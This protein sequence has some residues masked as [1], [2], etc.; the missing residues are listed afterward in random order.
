MGRASAQL[1]Q[2]LGRLEQTILAVWLRVMRKLLEMLRLHLPA[3][4]AGGG[5]P[6][7]NVKRRT[8]RS[9]R[10]AGVSPLALIRHRPA[11]VAGRIPSSI[12]AQQ[13]LECAGIQPPAYTLGP[14]HYGGDVLAIASLMLLESV[15]HWHWS[16]LRSRH[17]WPNPSRGETDVGKDLGKGN[18]SLQRR[19]V[20]VPIHAG[21]FIEQPAALSQPPG[22]P[23]S[24]LVLETRGGEP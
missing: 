11:C 3:A 9:R 16:R 7:H 15:G 8:R 12:D 18:G 24:E 14:R 2:W 21:G 20:Q 5:T 19:Q 23:L 10:Q 1:G 6:Y 4:L 17:W 13:D 22:K